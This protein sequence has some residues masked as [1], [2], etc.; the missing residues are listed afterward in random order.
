[1]TESGSP[2]TT[3]LHPED[4]AIKGEYALVDFRSKNV[5]IC[6]LEERP[7]ILIPMEDNEGTKVK[8]HKNLLFEV[9]QY[10]VDVKPVAPYLVV[11]PKTEA[12]SEVFLTFFRSFITDFANFDTAEVLI[13]FIIRKYDEWATFFGSGRLSN[14]EVS[15]CTGVLG[16]LLVLDFYVDYLGPSAINM[17]WGPVRHRHDFEFD[18]FSVEVKST[19]NPI[20]QEI[21]IHGLNQLSSEVDHP[22]YLVSVKMVPDPLG[23]SLEEL[24]KK[25][26]TKGV[27]EWQLYEKLSKTGIL[28]ESIKDYSGVRIGK[29]VLITYLIDDKFPS[30]QRKNLDKN[31]L[32]RLSKLTYSLNLSGLH[33]KESPPTIGLSMK[34]VSR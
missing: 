24:L 17:W 1:M 15:V 28:R 26:I 9:A 14:N 6:A 20:S 10:S 18:E 34:S 3:A 19:I 13:D 29:F 30:L 33:S 8:F 4:K 27:S 11:S 12:I 25:L 2:R 5:W 16:E 21:V 32:S 22:G 31:I 7:I 23:F